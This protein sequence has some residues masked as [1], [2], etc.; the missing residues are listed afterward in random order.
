MLSFCWSCLALVYPVHHDAQTL[1]SRRFYSDFGC[2]QIEIK[3]NWNRSELNSKRI[4]EI[5]ANWDQN[6]SEIKGNSSSKNIFES[7][8]ILHWRKLK[9][10][11]E[12]EIEVN[13]KFLLKKLRWIRNWNQGNQLEKR[14][15]DL[16]R[17][18]IVCIKLYIEF[19]IF[20]HAFLP[21]CTGR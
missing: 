18:K 17:E 5:K 12:F 16:L 8:A 15:F 13:R 4:V 11:R 20:I 21:F 3:A 6:Q 10:K 19:S 14:R 1:N 2:L 7:K 9:S